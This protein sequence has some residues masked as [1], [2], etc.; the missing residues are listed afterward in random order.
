MTTRLLFKVLNEDGT[1]CHGGAGR[2]PLPRDG[3]P[4]KPLTVRGPLVPCRNGLHLCRPKDLIRWLGPAIWTV[5]VP[6]GVE[7]VAC[8]D[9]IVV[10]SARLERRLTTWNARTARHFACDCAERVLHRIADPQAAEAVRVARRFADGLAT[11][12]ELAAAREAAWA[13][14][15]TAW[16][17]A[18]TA[19]G[20]AAWA[21]AWAAARAAGAV[22]GA[23]THAAAEAA[24]A[25]AR[26]AAAAAGDAERMWQIQ[27][28]M[29]YLKGERP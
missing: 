27:R 16:T 7:E 22:V 14:A 4:G 10:R 25:A 12:Q 19:V 21:A 9:K 1:A 28:L 23:A 11:G 26:A 2:W 3:N 6:D 17:V 15:W 8:D 18:G 20:A 13:T 29:E 24:A 5:Q